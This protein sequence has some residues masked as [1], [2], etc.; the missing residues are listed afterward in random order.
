LRKVNLIDTINW[1][2]IDDKVWTCDKN[3]GAGMPRGK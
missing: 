2:I 3:S 1:T